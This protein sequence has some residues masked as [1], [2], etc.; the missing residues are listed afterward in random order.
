MQCRLN[1]VERR[2]A[3]S[4]R[5]R[6]ADCSLPDGPFPGELLALGPIPSSRPHTIGAKKQR[7]FFIKFFSGVAPANQTEESKVCELPGR[8][9][10]LVPECPFACK[11]YTK[12]QVH[13]VLEQIPDSFLESFFG[14]FAGATPDF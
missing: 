13:G 9:P 8:S 2:C 11:Y 6:E 10:E 4:M 1:T 12:P 7:I 14:W 5:D 3:L